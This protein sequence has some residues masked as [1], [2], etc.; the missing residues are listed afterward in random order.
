MFRELIKARRGYLN[1][2]DVRT[3]TLTEVVRNLYSIKLFAYEAIFERTI[4]AQREI[5]ATF[6]RKLG[7][8]RAF[9]NIISSCVPAIAA[10]GEPFTRDTG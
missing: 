7:T 5:E 1:A 9:G 8:T 10:V 6:A 2:L 4:A 3:D